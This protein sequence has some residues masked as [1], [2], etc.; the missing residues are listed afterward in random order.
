[1][2]HSYDQDKNYLEQL[3][4]VNFSFNKY[5][6]LIRRYTNYKEKFSVCLLKV[7]NFKAYYHRFG[8]KC[9]HEIVSYVY[10]RLKKH[11]N[12]RGTVLMYNYNMLLLI[13]WDFNNQDEIK[14]FIEEILFEF[15]EPCNI[16]DHKIKVELNAGIAIYPE[17]S[18]KIE[19]LLRYSDIALSNSSKHNKYK[20]FTSNMYIDTI[21]N[22]VLNTDLLNALAKDEFILYYQPQVN[23]Y[24][25]KIYGVE[26]LIRWNHPLYGMLPSFLFIDTLIKNGMINK[27]GEWVVQKACN[28]NKKWAQLGYKGMDMFI[29]V[30]PNQLKDENFYLFIQNVLEREKINPSCI[31]I[32]ITEYEPFNTKNIVMDNLNNLRNLGVKIFLDDFGT[33]YSFLNNLCI[34]PIDGIKI[35]RFFIYDIMTNDR[36]RI[37]IKKIIELANELDIDV[38]VEGIE[39]KEQL[40]YLKEIGCYKVQGY[41]F[42]KPMHPDD[43]VK[44]F[45]H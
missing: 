34:L 28:Q 41:Y 7:V 33:C 24:N 42:G 18:E 8:Y 36:K 1:M 17:N 37:V 38:I 30:S 15:E 29:N 22:E 13:L 39:K 35:D 6:D 45:K 16:S 9:S 10:M 12:G 32:E 44:L 43:I 31:N 23:L 14:D 27:V 4:N 25:E 26:A 20:I 40:D 3:Q 21:M 2:V 11:V 5:Q 19:E